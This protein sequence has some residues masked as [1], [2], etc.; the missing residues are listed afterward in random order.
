MH[1]C[2]SAHAYESVRVCKLCQLRA[3]GE[4]YLALGGLSGRLVSRWS[5]C[6]ERLVELSLSRGKDEGKGVRTSG[7][8]RSGS[9]SH[10]GLF[11]R[12]VSCL[13]TQGPMYSRTAVRSS[14]ARGMESSQRGLCVL[15]L[16]DVLEA[17]SV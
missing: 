9:G 14:V 17:V 7:S 12:Q 1:A 15:A 5:P 13:S 3:L 4:V 8:P 16:I 10:S 11:A 6:K 2:R